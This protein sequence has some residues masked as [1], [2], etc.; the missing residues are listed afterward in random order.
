MQ[1]A[2]LLLIHQAVGMSSMGFGYS[3]VVVIRPDL[4]K[5]WLQDQQPTLVLQS[6]VV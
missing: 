6:Q 5:A 1:L 2:V 3:D 4:I